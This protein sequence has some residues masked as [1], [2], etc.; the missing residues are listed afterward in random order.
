MGINCGTDPI[1]SFQVP[2]NTQVLGIYL[3]ASLVV[4][5]SEDTCDWTRCQKVKGITIK[6]F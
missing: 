6:I 1:S 4:T 3:I 5:W 2:D